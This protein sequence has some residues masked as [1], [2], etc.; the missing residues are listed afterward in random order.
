MHVALSADS[1]TQDSVC[2]VME[3]E[4]ATTRRKHCTTANMR[5]QRLQPLEVHVELPTEGYHTKRKIKGMVLARKDRDL[6]LEKR[7]QQPSTSPARSKGN[8]CDQKQAVAGICLCLTNV[9]PRLSQNCIVGWK[10][11]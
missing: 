7:T 8:T 3:S 4:L 1:K 11:S 9:S 2:G 10:V 5:G 6:R